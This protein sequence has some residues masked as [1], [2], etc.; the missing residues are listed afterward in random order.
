MTRVVDDMLNRLAPDLD[1]FQ[2]ASDAEKARGVVAGGTS[3]ARQRDIR[4][5]ALEQGASD[6]EALVQ[7]VTSLIDAFDS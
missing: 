4:D 1:H 5:M 6:R 3:A 7:V 2:S